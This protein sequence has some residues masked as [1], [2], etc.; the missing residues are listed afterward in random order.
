VVVTMSRRSAARQ[1]ARRRFVLESPSKMRA[2]QL[3]GFL[4]KPPTSVLPSFAG[5]GS[6]EARPLVTTPPIQAASTSPEVATGTV[7]QTSR[8][9]SAFSRTLSYLLHEA[10]SIL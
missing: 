1:N 10:D 7:F 5:A 2:T 3:V 9:A 8:P 6:L 4:L